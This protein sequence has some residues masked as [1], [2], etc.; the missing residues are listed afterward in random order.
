MFIHTQLSE[1][2]YALSFPSFSQKLLSACKPIPGMRWDG[3][4]WVGPYDAYRLACSALEEE[5]ICPSPPPILV[6]T[7]GTP[8]RSYQ[9]DGVS[10]LLSHPYA[11]LADDMGIGKSIQTIYAA[12]LVPPKNAAHRILIVAPNSVKHHW[13][14]QELPRWWGEWQS[15]PPIILPSGLTPSS[16]P[17]TGIVI[18]H[19]ELLHAW[20]DVLTEWGPDVFIIDEAQAL[21]NETSQ[22]TK[23][24]RK[25]AKVSNY[26]WALTGTPIRNRPKDLFAMAD[27]ID[28]GHFGEKFF[29]FGLRYCNGHQF[30]VEKQGIVYQH[31][32]FK[33]S[34]HEEELKE[35]LSHFMLRRLKSDVA[36]ELPPKT[37]ET[38]WL[39]Y[40]PKAKFASSS[41][42]LL[43]RAAL[44]AALDKAADA[45]LDEVISLVESHASEGQTNVVFCY[46]RATA[47]AI[48]THARS[49]KID[50]VLIHGGVPV[51]RR[52]KAIEESRQWPQGGLIVCTID[53]ASV[54][55]ELSH[56]TICTFAELTYDPTELLQAESRLHRSGQLNPVYIE[57]VIQKGSIDELVAANIVAKLSVLEGVVGKSE[58]TGLNLSLTLTQCEESLMADFAKAVGGM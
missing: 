31:W 26:R 38:V 56:A 10:F 50:A 6:E 37:R 28:P 15:M 36:L 16:L 29:G 33:G 3:R 42:L 7:S 13:Y 30:Q 43:N 45:K 9:V 55:I 54:G 46:R 57:Y 22:R 18:L 24:A 8:L 14:D 47:E 34:S 51:L 49:S 12:R 5:D 53:T 35:R 11:I 21:Q 39:D 23:A 41:S 19:Y 20:R 25:I 48:F 27:V 2:R 1:D 40:N 17:E 44:R 58:D 32:D 4:H 52:A